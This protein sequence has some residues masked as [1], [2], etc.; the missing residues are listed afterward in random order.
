MATTV[1]KGMLSFGLVTMPIRLYAA[2]RSK[3]VALHQLHKE[4]HTRIKQP[5]FCPHCNRFVNRTEIAKGYEY[6]KGQYILIEEDE[7]KKIAPPSSR[8]MDILKF[9]PES[10]VDPIYFDSS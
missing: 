6:E 10:A 4:C 1:W 7:L 3:H 5:L 9:V 8:T 2:A